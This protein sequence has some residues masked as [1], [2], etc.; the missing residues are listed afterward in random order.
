MESF[1]SAERTQ[2]KKKH[3][4][5]ILVIFSLFILF[6]FLT[7]AVTL[8]YHGILSFDQLF[9]PV[10]SDIA[11]SLSAFFL[12]S[13]IAK[14]GRIACLGL[15]IFWPVVN[16]A[17]IESILALNKPL[18]ISDLHY[19]TNG[20]FLENTLQALAYPIPYAILLA[21][22]IA[23]SAISKPLKSINIYL[24]IILFTASI[25]TTYF[26]SNRVTN[27]L[28]A[29]PLALT[30]INYYNTNKNQ[31]LLSEIKNKNLDNGIKNPLLKNETTTTTLEENK[32]NVLLIVLEG[33]P[34][35]Y[36]N[37]IQDYFDI[38]RNNIMPNL[39]KI[40]KNSQTTPSFVTHSQQTI[41]GLYS[42]L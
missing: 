21:I 32:K 37:S 7:R 3:N 38:P 34:G 8:N 13:I 2:C 36:I 10:I 35:A 25:S 15:L 18:S 17:S 23:F 41:R 14:I 42:M 24:S 29:N 6:S 22:F 33:I 16:F 27:W 28:Q 11:I 12:L 9:T 19:T 31:K 30:I 26:S 4:T 40:A 5:Y 1:L 20:G 39:S